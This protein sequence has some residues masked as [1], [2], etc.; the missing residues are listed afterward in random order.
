M[1]TP[2]PTRFVPIRL[3]SPDACAWACA[4][5]AGLLDVSVREGDGTLRPLL[6]R[7]P[8]E[9]EHAGQLAGRFE[10]GAW[11]TEGAWAV[12]DRTPVSARFALEPA[13]GVGLFARYELGP[14]GLLI[15]LD[16][17]LPED[18]TIEGRLVLRA[19]DA[20]VEPREGLGPA[21]EDGAGAIALPFRLGGGG[22]RRV[23]AL[24]RLT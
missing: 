3:E 7:A 15:E 11:G 4:L 24:L 10:F 12:L 23:S 16:A 14:G 17:A 22:A 5:G 6:E 2:A 18:G 13:P 1:P 9:V 21:I 20:A 19:R 8:P